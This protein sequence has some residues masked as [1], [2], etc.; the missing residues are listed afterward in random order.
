MASGAQPV[1]DP[2]SP[3]GLTAYYQARFWAGV[4]LHELRPKYELV[5]RMLVELPDVAAVLRW[6]TLRVLDVILKSA[7]EQQHKSPPA[8]VMI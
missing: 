6:H 1:S 8:A 2:A 4:R 7:L 3:A 5:A